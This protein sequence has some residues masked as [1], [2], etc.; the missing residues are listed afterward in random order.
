[1]IEKA[2]LSLCLGPMP[3]SH[4]HHNH[5]TALPHASAKSDVSLMQMSVTARLIGALAIIAL[6]WLGVIAVLL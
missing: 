6:V 5:T 3:H 1:M 2:P 4:H